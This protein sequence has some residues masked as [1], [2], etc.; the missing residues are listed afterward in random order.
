M[1]VAP[2]PAPDP[3]FLA[4]V[5]AAM[6]RAPAPAAAPDPGPGLSLA[7]SA[8][9][10]CTV[11]AA[12]AAFVAADVVT[13]GVD[14]PAAVVLCVTAMFVAAFVLVA[15]AWPVRTPDRTRAGCVSAATAFAMAL[16]HA[17]F[18]VAI[19]RK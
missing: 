4:A 6:P 9:C 2:A 14:H 13:D 1:P 5:V 11:I 7:A 15:I 12:A 8:A 16:M 19:F 18:L 3:A 10:N 17:G